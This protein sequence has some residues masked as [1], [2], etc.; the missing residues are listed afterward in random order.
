MR[1]ATAARSA[2]FFAPV[3]SHA[4][5]AV[6]RRPLAERREGD[7]RA[8]VLEDVAPGLGLPD[9]EALR[10]LLDRGERARLLVVGQRVRVDRHDAVRR[11]AVVLG[12]AGGQQ[13]EPRRGP[14]ERHPEAGRRPAP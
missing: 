1:S 11:H 13:V 5:F 7:L 4:V 9:A 12:P 3:G 10:L 8:A 2:F 14:R 6:E